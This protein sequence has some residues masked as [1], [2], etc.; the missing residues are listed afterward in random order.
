MLRELI[1]E[2]ATKSSDTEMR[3]F[4]V[5][6]VASPVLQVS[7]LKTKKDYRKMIFIFH[8]LTHITFLLL[9]SF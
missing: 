9:L 4:A 6:K 8:I 2:F 3:V 7:N 5:S 1:S